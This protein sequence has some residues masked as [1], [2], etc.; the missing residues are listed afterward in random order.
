MARAQHG[1][2]A[3]GAVVEALEPRKLLAITWDGSSGDNLWSNPANWNL[4]R[5]PGATD[6]VVIPNVAGAPTITFSAAAGTVSILTLTASEAFSVTGGSLTLTSPLANVATFDRPFS[7]SGGTFRTSTTGSDV[8]FNSGFTLLSGTFFMAG[9]AFLLA[10]GSSSGGSLSGNGELDI[11][12][13]TTFTFSGGTR[14]INDLNID[15]N[16]GS[17]NWTATNT[18]CDNDVVFFLDAAGTFIYNAGASSSILQGA[19]SGSRISG[20]GTFVKNNSVSA[21]IAIEAAFDGTVNINNGTLRLSGGDGALDTS[22]DFAVGANGTLDLRAGTFDFLAASSVSGSTFSVSGATVT[23]DGIIGVTS[24]EVIGGTLEYNNAA[25]A[26]AVVFVL[27]AGVVTTDA[28]VLSTAGD[29]VVSGTFSWTGGDLLAGAN[30]SDI[31]GVRILESATASIS[32]PA[33]LLGRQIFNLRGT[34]TFDAPTIN[35]QPFASIVN[36]GGQFVLTGDGVIGSGLGQWDNTGTVTKSG[37]GRTVINMSFDG[38]SIATVSTTAV[39][40]GTLAIEGAMTSADDDF[41]VNFGCVLEF[42]GA[43]TQVIGGEQ[44]ISGSAGGLRLL[45]TGSFTCFGNINMVNGFVTIDGSATFTFGVDAGSNPAPTRSTRQL[46]VNS[47]TMEINGTPWT[48]TDRVLLSGGTIDTNL[49]SNTWLLEMSGGT[50][51]GSGNTT[52]TGASAWSGGFMD[53]SGTTVVGSGATLTL[54]GSLSNPILSRPLL[55]DGTGVLSWT[56]GNISMTGATIT[57]GATADFLASSGGSILNTSGANLVSLAGDLI[58]SGALSASSIQVPLNMTA[59]STADIFVT[60][61]TL[62]LG[63]GGDHDGDFSVSLGA[64]LQFSGGTHTFAPGQNISGAGNVRVTGPAVVSNI[65]SFSNTGSVTVAGGTMSTLAGG[66]F[67]TGSLVVSGGTATLN[68]ALTLTTGATVSGGALSVNA[69]MSWPALNMTVG[70][71]SGS[72]AVALTGAAAGTWSGGTITDVSVQVLSGSVFEISGAG[73]KSLSGTFINLGETNFTSGTITFNNGVI[74]N[75]AGGLFTINGAAAM[76]GAGGTNR[77]DNTATVVKSAGGIF[78]VTVP[79]NQDG[80]AGATNIDGGTLVLAAGGA[81][82]GD[83]SIDPGATL[84]LGGGHTLGVGSAVSGGGT[85]EIVGGNNTFSSVTNV[86]GGVTHSGGA[87]TFNANCLGGNFTFSGGSVTFAGAAVLSPSGVVTVSGATVT[88]SSA[89]AWPILDFSAGTI[90]GAGNLALTSGTIAS[91]WTGGTMSGTGTTSTAASARLSVSGPDAK[92]LARPLTNAGALTLGDGPLTF[93]GAVLTNSAAGIVDVAGAA[94]LEQSP[95]VNVFDN[96]GI[97]NKTSAANATVNVVFNLAAPASRLNVVGGRISLLRGGA[98]SGDFD[99]SFGATLELAS[100]HTTDAG[101][102]ISGAGGD[103]LISAGASVLGGPVTGLTTVAHAG[104]NTSFNAAL[105]AVN[106]VFSGGTATAAVAVSSSNLVTISGAT[107]VVNATSPWQRLDLSAGTLGGSGTVTLGATGGLVSNWTGGAMSGAGV[108]TVATGARLTI[109]GNVTLARDLTLVGTSD[110]DW[111]SGDV[112][113]TGG[114]IRVLGT[115]ADFNISSPGSILN[116]SGVNSVQVTGDIEKTGTVISTVAVPVSMLSQA[117]ADINV[118]AGTLVL[119]GGGAHDGDFSVSS[120][121]TLRFAGGT[122]TF[123]AG[124]GISGAG[125]VEFVAG[126]IT[127]LQGSSVSTFR[128][129]GATV[130]MVTGPFSAS[131]LVVSSGTLTL[132]APFTATVLTL[133]GGTIDGSGGLTIPA[134]SGVST[135]SGGAMNGTGLTT[136]SAGRQLDITAAAVKTLGRVLENRGTL[137]WVSGNINLNGGEL[138]NGVVGAPG[139]MNFTSASTATAGGTGG[140]ITN[141]PGSTIDVAGT[142]TIGGTSSPVVFNSAG[143]VNVN[144]VLT[145]AG[146]GTASADMT[147]L[148]MD[149]LLT[150]SSN[151]TFNAATLRLNDGFTFIEAVTITLNNSTILVNSALVD[152]TPSLLQFRGG[153]RFAGTPATSAIVINGAGVAQRQSSSAGAVVFDVPIFCSVQGT[154]GLG[155]SGAVGTTTLNAGGTL[156][157]RT[158]WGPTTTV[159]IN[160]TAPLFTSTSMVD[161]SG[162]LRTAVPITFAGSVR[163]GGSGTAGLIDSTASTGSVRIEGTFDWL[164][165][166]ISVAGG[167]VVAPIGVLNVPAGTGVSTLNTTLENFRTVNLQ[168]RGFQTPGVLITNRL[169]SAINVS[170]AAAIVDTSPGS[171]AGAI[172]NEGLL[173]VGLQGS[174]SVAATLPFLNAPLS[175]TV[176]VDGGAL[177]LGNVENL[178]PLSLTLTGGTWMVRNGG[179][180]DFALP[181]RTNAANIFIDG[182]TSTF[183]ALSTLSTNQGAILLSG[184]ADL[185]IAPFGGLLANDGLIDVGAGS[186]VSVAGAFT[187]AAAASIATTIAAAGAPDG[188]GRV[189]VTGS[190]FLSGAA[191]VRFA[192]GYAPAIGDTATFLTSPSI[193]GQFSAAV[194]PSPDMGMRFLIDSSGDAISFRVLDPADFNLDGVVDPDDL[195]DFIA[196]FFGSPANPNTDFNGDGV[197]DPDDLSDYIAAFFG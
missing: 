96:A 138:R 121:A 54:P 22:G 109:Q 62:L 35:T 76:T 85:L 80:A 103:L 118:G 191:T 188:V 184:G 106:L 40:G 20:A 16:G 84:R 152:S 74:E 129:L 113:M 186:V 38:N 136:I 162:T 127:G 65:V 21:N 53:G 192:P 78:T 58:R 98:H 130:S 67:S 194:L 43:N 97:V 179:S 133:S 93:A 11:A 9:S 172:I 13:G 104:G 66:V 46:S 8:T 126:T 143:P 24:L 189:E 142:H 167:V 165:G 117:N 135:W 125:G 18:T 61:G 171:I 193:S 163:F 161:F 82:L 68:Q 26:T 59:Q 57:V 114:V 169:D 102:S 154:L 39:N 124:Q 92:T 71:L 139:T 131:L 164:S 88:L 52:L 180:I 17:L 122:H 7:Q 33:R 5:V 196:G 50:L 147:V 155:S 108:T 185:A 158:I 91:T 1:M 119:S 37:S 181:V 175:G 79:F 47:G 10:G 95:G 173:R 115:T 105:S 29:I 156:A 144:G 148:D 34:V 42:G 19:G 28:S 168:G 190:A 128:V 116:T 107:V 6:D 94:S 23:M 110:L 166:A 111:L 87:T 182:A 27:Q 32:G 30:G 31:V 120:G 51:T 195:S 15:I 90:T 89:N 187:Q 123:A 141:G 14:T 49:T 146:G 48:V 100:V 4:N 174:L 137:N 25:E 178:S 176:I 2:G 99:I 55:V 197:V 159:V 160:G 44:T 73:A 177:V 72:A 112:S 64:T 3:P 69:T 41:F 153:S 183:P 63:G 134:G 151:Y 101:S 132:G 86:T 145:I 56:G 77:F 170:G 157:G 12:N 45:N 81:H 140:L 75:A 149:G 70:T 83:F 36:F 60:G 150:F